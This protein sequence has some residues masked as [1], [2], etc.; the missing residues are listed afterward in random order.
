[1][2]RLILILVMGGFIMASF[3]QAQRT[4][5]TDNDSGGSPVAVVSDQIVLEISAQHVGDFSLGRIKSL[6]NLNKLYGVSKIE[7]LFPGE[8]KAKLGAETL[9][10][11]Y[12]LT[13]D[14]QKGLLE[15]VL[16]AYRADGAVEKAEAIYIHRLYGTPDDPYFS[17]QWYLHQANDHDID[18]PEAWDVTEGEGTVI[19][20]IIDTGI[21]YSHA[22]L[23]SHIWH[24]PD[25]I[26]GNGQDDDGNGYID[27]MFGW[28]WVDVSQ[29][30]E[31]E[32]FVNAD[33]DPRDFNGHGTHCAGIASAVTDNGIGIAGV[34]WDSQLMALRVGWS[35]TL[36]DDGVPYEAGLVRMDFAAQAI[37]Y[38]VDKGATAVNSS[39]GSSNSGGLGTACDYAQTNGVLIVHAAGNDNDNSADYLA[40]RTEVLTVAAT[41]QSDQKASFSNYGDWVDVSAPG[42]DIYS[43]YSSHYTAGYSY[44]SGTSMATPVAVGITALLK[45]IYPWWDSD[46]IFARIVSAADNIDAVNP[47]YEGMLGSGRVNAYKAVTG[48]SY[49]IYVG[50]TISENTTWYSDYVYMVTSNLTIPSGVTLTIEAGTVVKLESGQSIYVS[51]ILDVQGTSGNPV[52][53][54]SWKDDSLG[55]DSNGDGGASSP[56]SGDWRYIQFHNGSNTLDYCLIKYGGIYGSVNYPVVRVDGVAPSIHHNIIRYCYGGIYY[57]YSGGSPVT[58]SDNQIHTTYKSGIWFTGSEVYSSPQIRNNMIYGPGSSVVGLYCNATN[59]SAR[60]DNNWIQDFNT[61]GIQASRCDAEITNNTLVQTGASIDKGTGIYLSH[62]CETTIEGNTISKYDVGIKSESGSG[63]PPCDLNISFNRIINNGGIGIHLRSTNIGAYDGPS[64]VLNDND[65]YGNDSLNLYLGEYQNPDVTVI[66]AE[67]NWWGSSDSAEIAETIFDHEDD[68]NSPTA[69]FIP[70]RTSPIQPSDPD[71]SVDPSRVNV[72]LFPDSATTRNLVIHNNGVAEMLIF[73]IREGVGG[74]A[75]AGASTESDALLGADL[76]WLDEEPTTGM[77]SPGDSAIIQLTFN[78]SGLDDG[79]YVGYLIIDNNDLDADP[80]VVPITLDV[81][82]VFV[83]SPNGGEEFEAGESQLVVWSLIDSV[84]VDSVSAWY[85][86]D[87]GETYPYL[88]AS[89]IQDSSHINWVIPNTPSD[90]CKVK[91]EAFYTVGLTAEDESDSLFAITESPFVRGD[92]NG[93]G[94]IELGDVVYLINYL[95]REGPAPDP[96]WTGDCNCDEIVELGDVV[97]LIN[98]LFRG[99]PAPGC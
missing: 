51:G 66:N 12:R 21:L 80:F 91:T 15:T 48:A 13:F 69:D 24:N 18:A 17:N 75:M 78:S 83:I 86:T 11:F 14:P 29:G 16:E 30:W 35:D 95:Y 6:N 23:T 22:D 3:A 93:D 41:D 63:N 90:S 45:S 52:A 39:W 26:L 74:L 61:Y 89:G 34:S 28:D 99:G 71:I 77:V 56:N 36:W 79:S 92:A 72:N 37:V 65:I 87:G 47:G 20:C 73:S 82:H 85:S 76:T 40:Q 98:Y 70:Y 10:K 88:I 59:N 27:D 97:Y 96:L 9:K 33:N 4:V 1:M 7:P 50:G 44:L 53:F 19:L 58:I 2:K 32:D 55:G 25:E 8:H 43:T 60:I 42:V 54:T 57:S 38:A 94:V 84:L 68:P 5:Q 46:S 31:G 67:N 62:G 49:V 64:A 81:S